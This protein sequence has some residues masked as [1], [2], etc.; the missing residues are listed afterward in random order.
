VQ[1]Q[2]KRV[3]AAASKKPSK[4]DPH[5]E[6]A[7]KGVASKALMGKTMKI[8]RGSGLPKAPAKHV[9]HRKNAPRGRR[10]R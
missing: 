5:E 6:N 7:K 9:H 10:A 3:S 8:D 2:H 4:R 1:E